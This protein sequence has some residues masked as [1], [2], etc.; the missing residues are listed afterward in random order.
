[1]RPVGRIYLERGEPVVVLI[2]WGLKSRGES[3]GGPRNVLI[4]RETGEMVVRSFR[5]L[6]PAYTRSRGNDIPRFAAF[7]YLDPEAAALYDELKS[8]PCGYCGE[9]LDPSVGW[10]EAHD[11]CIANLPGVR[12]ACCGHG[13]VAESDLMVAGGELIETK[14]KRFDRC[15]VLFDDGLRLDGNAARAAMR[16]LGGNPPDAPA[17]SDS[18]REFGWGLIAEY[19]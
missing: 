14:G 8:K 13:D 5:G 19:L 10:W 2:Q 17:D 3:Y 15:Y 16:M 7:E 12:A 11:P 6:R 1:M 4:E 18:R 9:Q